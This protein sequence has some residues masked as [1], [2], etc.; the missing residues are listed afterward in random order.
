MFDFVRKHTRLMLGLIVVLIIPSFVFFGIDGYQRMNDGANATVAKV[1]GRKVTQADWDLAHRRAVEN[2]RQRAPGVDASLFDS[3]AAKKESLDSLVRERVLMAAAY[4]AHLFPTDE[5]LQRLFATDPQFAPL[6]NPDGSV[7]KELLAA[8]GMSSEAF[9]Q[10]L[11]SDYGMQQVL[12]GVARSAVAPAVVA[13]KALDALLQQR[14]V[15][16]ERFDAAAYRAKV[17]PTDADLEAWHKAN[18]EQFRAPEQATIEWVLLEP[19]VLGRDVSVT[20]AGLQQYYEQNA[21]R[22]TLAEER[23]ARHVLVKA[24]K[25]MPAAERQKAKAKAEQLLAQLRAKPEEFPSVAKASS[26]DPGS[27]EQGGDLGFF[28]RG[29]MVKPFEDAVFSMKPGEISPVIETDF[30]YHVIQLTEI[31]GGQKRPFAEVR[32]EIEDEVRRAE[33]QRK[34]SEAAEQFSNLVYEQPDSLQPVIDKFKLEKR[35]ATVQRRPAPGAEGPLASVK[36]LEAVF[37]DDPLRNKKNTDAVE[38]GT[39]QLVAARVTAYQPERTLPLAEVK[40]RVRDRVVAEQAAAL[41]RKDGEARLAAVKDD[42]A[43]VLPLSATVSRAQPGN[44]PRA[45]V[46]AALKADPD[47]LPLTLG[48]DLGTEGYAVLRVTQ[49]LPRDPAAGG[50]EAALRGQFAQALANAEALAYYE[51]LKKRFKVSVTPPAAA[52]SAP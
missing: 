6:R 19:A 46:E 27:A 30:G 38:V 29:A 32:A 14:S 8:Q 22:Y 40:D 37:K 31:K 17:S 45:V 34:Y 28:G 2:M 7:R 44:L 20:E 35:S 52:A 48:V 16:V 36:L 12:G 26:D 47:K 24:E 23:R 11:R 33:A 1:D 10:Q 21:S 42:K 39:S 49:V 41:S 43:A 3:P 51:S 50:G 9:A 15:Q 5:R 13:G 18:A 4:E 25:E